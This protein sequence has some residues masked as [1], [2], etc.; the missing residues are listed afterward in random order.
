M[1]KAQAAVELTVIASLMMIL[2]FLLFEFGETKINESTSMLQVSEARNTVDRLAKAVTEVRNEGV[3]ARR[4]VYVKIPDRVNPNRILIGNTTITLG[5]Y[6]LNGTSDINAATDF[7]VVQG[8][9]FPTAPGTYW[10]WVISRQ[11]YVQIGSSFGVDP[12]NVYFE[13][14]PTNS[15]STNIT[16]TNLGISTVNVTSNLTWSDSETSATI[17]G[18]SSMSFLLL[19]GST[20]SQLINLSVTANS[21]ASFGLH[22]GYISITTNLSER[23]VI[24]ILVNVVSQPVGLQNVSY[25]IID[26]YNDSSYTYS[27]TSFSPSSVIYY[28]VKSYDS[29][30]S[31]INSTVT[32]R[33][34]DLYSTL[35]SEQNYSA[36]GGT[37]IYKGNYSLASNASP[38]SWRITAYDIGGARTAMYVTVSALDSTTTLIGSTTTIP[39]NQSQRAICRD[40]S[41]YIHVVWL[42][43]STTLKYARS[44][45]NGITFAVFD[46]NSS[47]DAKGTPYISCNG[48]V[49][50]VA[51]RAASAIAIHQ[52]TDNGVTWLYQQPRTANV[53]NNLGI[54]AVGSRVYVEYTSYNS[55]TGYN[56]FVFFNS[57]DSGST[58]GGNTIVLASSNGQSSAFNGMSVSGSGITSDSIFGLVYNGSKTDFLSSSN[59][60]QTWSSAVVIDSTTS[61]NN[62]CMASS[63]SNVSISGDKWGSASQDIYHYNSSAYASFSNTQIDLDY[64]PTLFNSSYYSSVTINGTNPVIFWSQK[65]NT[66][67][68]DYN[69]TIAYSSYNGSSWSTPVNFTQDTNYNIYVNTKLSNTASCLEFV[70]KNG[71]ASPYNVVYGRLG[72]CSSP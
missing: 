67:S 54:E 17:N 19:T 36:N 2:L 4:K 46:L 35:M 71:T 64:N 66:N 7:T 28:S 48:G 20:N 12:S 52:S 33:V 14:F 39:F 25:L 65:N 58:W 22:S 6:T 1:R 60:G 3:G 56:D 70:Y 24:P 26:T 13:L 50:W 72:V 15:T 37:G 49:V 53:V 16:L 21:N 31:L 59:A 42:Y 43:N 40:S 23:E 18:T 5:V 11:G 51:Y 55:T 38:G 27:N 10:V 63:G 45:D 34:Y 44:T 47:S 68:G 9:F 8:G 57:S 62:T 41:N 69:Y 32:V 30:N 29:T 61:V